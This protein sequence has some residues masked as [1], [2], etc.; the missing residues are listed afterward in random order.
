VPSHSVPQAKNYIRKTLWRLVDKNP[1]KTEIT[2]LWQ[3]FG[4]EC[5]YCGKPLNKDDRKAH[6]D[7]LDANRAVN[8]NHISNR[9]L[10]CNICNGDEK[11]ENDWEKFLA[12]KCGEDVA[13]CVIR[14]SRIREWQ[15]QCGIPSELDPAVVAVVERA[16]RECKAKLDEECNRIRQLLSKS[17]G[18]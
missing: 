1:S 8:R 9:V 10:A 4:S 13:A 7:H 6:I 11:R 14:T 17:G 2:R 15:Q 12:Q 3:H 16:I 5:A 18:A